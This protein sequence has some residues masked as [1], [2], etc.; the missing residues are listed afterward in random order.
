MSTM[1]MDTVY[2]TAL[3]E[4][5]VATVRDTP[6]ARRRWRW[7]AGTGVFLGLTVAAGGVALASGIFT[8]PGAP[9]NSPLGNVVTA[10]RTGSAT[11]EIGAP[12]AGATD[13]SLTFTC[14]TAGTFDFPDGSSASCGAA[15][16]IRP[17]I[18]RTSIDVVP[19]TVGVDNV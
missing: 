3:R 7:R 5:L 19:L 6:R 13:L 15:D 10:T 14:L 8:L 12:P 16:L 9:V 1:E 18:Y 4:V 2:A 17:P 11:I